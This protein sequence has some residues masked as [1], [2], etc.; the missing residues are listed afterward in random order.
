MNRV[1][2]P[3]EFNNE[4]DEVKESENKYYAQSV[5]RLK[6]LTEGHHDIIGG[7]VNLKLPSKGHQ[8]AYMYEVKIVVHMGAEHIAATE[9]GK[10]IQ[11]T[12][13]RALDAI[14]RQVHEHREKQRNY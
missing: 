12:L 11:S 6:Q 1:D 5:D 9:Q 4:I 2:F 14:E 8:T 7:A 10:Q 13:D 3:V